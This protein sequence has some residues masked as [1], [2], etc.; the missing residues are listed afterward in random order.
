MTSTLPYKI[1][2]KKQKSAQFKVYLQTVSLI[3]IMCVWLLDTYNIVQYNIVQNDVHLTIQDN[4]KKK[5]AQFKV[6][7]QTVSLI[8]IMCVLTI[9]QI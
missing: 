4:S 1:T 6:Y 8:A 2:Q 3:A 7:L 5:S 9:R